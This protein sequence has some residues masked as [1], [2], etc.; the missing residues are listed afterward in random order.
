MA[1]K[2]PAQS[3]QEALQN[4][5]LSP[6]EQAELDAEAV[7]QAEALESPQDT[8]WA[9]RINRVLGPRG[10]EEYMFSCHI[11]DLPLWDKLQEKYPK[12]GQ[13]RGWVLKNGKIVKRLEYRIAPTFEPETIEQ[14][15][16][17]ELSALVEA[18]S[19]Q[20]DLLLRVLERP[21]QQITS[22]PVT[23]PTDQFVKIATLLSG[24]M[25]PII[26]QRQQSDPLEYVRTGIELAKAAGG[27][28]DRDT[29]MMDIL[30]SAIEGPLGKALSNQLEA[31]QNAIR[32]LAMPPPA[33]TVAVPVNPPIPTQPIPQPQINPANNPL[34]PLIPY[35]E[36]ML[37]AAEKNSPP[38]LYA[39][40]LADNLPDELWNALLIDN[41]LIDGLCE[42]VPR[43]AARKDWFM[44]VLEACRNMS[45]D[46]GDETIAPV[47]AASE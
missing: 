12:G 20:N 25:V 46:T 41:K 18:M 27:G 3:E 15:P 26:S 31:Q 32:N 42:R 5:I 38:E 10:P 33:P 24:F 35:L 9:I 4:E 45:D 34:G 7:L 40:L 21:P 1:R 2:T 44:R 36:P 39:N 19:R 47:H 43:M 30:K 13:F 37:I 22:Q 28:S 17:T 23:D 29:N 14:R 8:D 6:E 11:T 16:N